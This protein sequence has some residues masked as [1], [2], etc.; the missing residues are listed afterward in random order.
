MMSTLDSGPGYVSVTE[1]AKLSSCSERT[2]RRALGSGR[3]AG[4]MLDGRWRIP[5]DALV[6]LSRPVPRHLPASGHDPAGVTALVHDAVAPLVDALAAAIERA[7]RAEAQLE[8]LRLVVAQLEAAPALA[9]SAPSS[10]PSRPW[11][12]RL[13]GGSAGSASAAPLGGPTAPSAPARSS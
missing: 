9:G 4:V 5:V 13:F 1:A 11:W 10:S 3:L 12:R 2:V 7:V 6:S 8:Q